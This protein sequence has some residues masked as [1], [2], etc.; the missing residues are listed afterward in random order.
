[1]QQWVLWEDYVFTLVA[2]HPDPG[3][4]APGPAPRSCV[5]GRLAR[6]PP[7][8]RAAG[9]VALVAAVLTD[10]PTRRLRVSWSFNCPVPSPFHGD[11]RGWSVRGFES[12]S[13]RR[14]ARRS[15]K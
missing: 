12:H 2:L 13:L 7:G 6:K 4:R 9:A 1:M 14:T 11:N 10:P 15:G 8:Y 3:A 5:P